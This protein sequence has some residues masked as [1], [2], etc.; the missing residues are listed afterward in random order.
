[1]SLNMGMD[2]NHDDVVA[3]NSKSGEVDVSLPTSSQ[4]GEK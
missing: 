4:R 1:M 3:G 2:S